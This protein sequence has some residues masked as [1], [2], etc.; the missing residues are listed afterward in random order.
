[1]GGEVNIT[2]IEY[3]DLTWTIS[4]GCKNWSTGVC[5]GGG[6]TF[7]C[8]AKGQTK[9]RPQ[10]YP[11]GFLPTFYP[12]RLG[13]PMKRKKSAIIGVSFMGDLFGDWMLKGRVIP[14]IDGELWSGQGIIESILRT[15]EDCPQHIF[16]F[17]TKCPQ[18]LARWDPWPKNCFVG[19]SAT[20]NTTLLN[21]CYYLGHV[22]ASVKFI[23]LEPFLKWENLGLQYFKV[24]PVDW[25]IIG[26]ATGVGAKPPQLS[27]VQG[28]TEAAN[29]AGVPLFYKNNLLKYFP[30]LPQRREWPRREKP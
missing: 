17:L 11:Y 15:V 30:D 8:W 25:L 28:I 6:Q 12:Q 21:A 22:T 5:G 23:S 20:D 7:K 24:D 18:N 29:D 9:L 1:M 13:E 16:V 4:S 27:W 14:D 10:H 26:A 19:A 3:L 2:G